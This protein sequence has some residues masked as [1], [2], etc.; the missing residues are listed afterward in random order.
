MIKINSWDTSPNLRHQR[1]EAR[2]KKRIATGVI[3][4]WTLSRSQSRG[5]PKAW[6][7]ARLVQLQVGLQTRHPRL[8][9]LKRREPP[10]KDALLNCIPSLFNWA[11]G[12]SWLVETWAAGRW[13]HRRRRR[14]FCSSQSWKLHLLQGRT[15][16]LTSQTAL[17]RV[18]GHILPLVTKQ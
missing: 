3:T 12:R 14:E 15:P 1:L 18:P 17:G 10:R 7:A 11:L 8:S 6:W 9:L 5:Q 16:R 4:S 13:A 2:E